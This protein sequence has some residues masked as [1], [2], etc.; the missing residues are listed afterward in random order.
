M[1]VRLNTGSLSEVSMNESVESIEKDALICYTGTFQSMDGPVEVKVENLQ[2]IA[3]NYN[4]ILDKA[5][6]AAGGPAPLK[7]CAPVQLDHETKATHTIGRVTGRLEVRPVE[8]EGAQVMGLFGRATIMGAENV[9]KVK[10]GRW[11]H[12]SIGADFTEG[13]LNELTVTPFPAAPNA[14]MLS[15]GNQDMTK[16]TLGEYQ[17]RIKE[18]A[19]RAML[20]DCVIK[21]VLDAFEVCSADKERMKNFQLMVEA[22]KFY[23]GVTSY[24]KDGK[25]YVIGRYADVD[26]HRLSAD[27]VY[28]ACRKLWAQMER[29][30]DEHIE[31]D[32]LA[33]SVRDAKKVY[34]DAKAAGDKSAYL[35]DLAQTIKECKAITGVS[36]SEETKGTNMAKFKEFLT[37]FARLSAEAEKALSAEEGKEKMSYEEVKEKMAHYTKAK[38]HLMEE[39]KMSEEDAEKHLAEAKDEDIKQMSA[40]EDKKEEKRL[41]DKPEEEAK[42]M[43]RLTKMNEANAKLAQAL[44][45]S[46]LAKKKI[47]VV[48]RLASLRAKAKISPAEYK[49]IDLESWAKEDD[50]ITEARLSTF[51]K[52]SSVIDPRALGSVHGMSV[53]D[54]A[55]KVRMSDIE[56]ETRARMSSVPKEE[57]KEKGKELS[58]EDA[59]NEK[60]AEQV[61]QAHA[62]GAHMSELEVIHS[63]MAEGD[64]KKKM[65]EHIEKMKKMAAE[66]VDGAGVSEKESEKH[67][68]ALASTQENLENTIKETQRLMADLVG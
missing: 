7:F 34:Q 40:E 12:L 27:K 30:D 13:K 14:S 52:R 15:K 38:K 24:V 25:T 29:Y 6:M 9:A 54:I 28:D 26:G 67:M 59:Q 10:D 49:E 45:Q 33:V 17:N 11:I 3:D 46:R 66:S 37:K 1:I 48:N 41:A 58:D 4:A 39:K 31:A 18:H 65:G 62:A 23:K 51:E 60:I 56:K 5:S 64:A 21:Q 35:S 22:D 53:T 55:Q 16:L 50:K 42:K 57:P 44:E 61:R 68:A 20:S 19:T 63:M 36:L 32:E 43:A 47:S 2:L 8:I